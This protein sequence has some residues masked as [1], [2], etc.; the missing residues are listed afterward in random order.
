M[1]SSPHPRPPQG[2]DIDNTGDHTKLQGTTVL[3]MHESTSKKLD[4]IDYCEFLK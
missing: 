1:E 2:R 3:K 4:A